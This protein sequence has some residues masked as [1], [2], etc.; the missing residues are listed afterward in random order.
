MNFGACM[1]EEPITSGHWFSFGMKVGAR[2]LQCMG[3]TLAGD[4]TK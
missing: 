1:A 4:I 2:T 3:K